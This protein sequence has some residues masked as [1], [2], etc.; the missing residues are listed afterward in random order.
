MIPKK[1]YYVWFGDKPMGSLEKGCLA[2][3]RKYCPDYEIVKI[4]ESNFDVDRYKFSSLS[5]KYKIWS[6]VSDVARCHVLSQGGG[7]YLDTDIMLT[8]KIDDLLQYDQVFFQDRLFVNSAPMMCSTN[9]IEIQDTILDELESKV[10][11]DTLSGNILGVL[12]RLMH[13]M[14]NLKPIQKQ[15]FEDNTCVLDE[16]FLPWTRKANEKAYGIHCLRQSWVGSKFSCFPD[17]Y[18][19]FDVYQNGVYDEE[20]TRRLSTNKPIGRID[21]NGCQFNTEVLK[22]TNYF[23]NENVVRVVKPEVRVERYGCEDVVPSSIYEDRGALIE[24]A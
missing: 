23:F 6:Y 15:V 2:S 8:R 1:I 7:I 17:E 10:H 12:N 24:Y 13:H 11:G 9:G 19:G 4:D 5:Y 14:Y 22:L 18:L 20:M 3:W 16:S 21:L